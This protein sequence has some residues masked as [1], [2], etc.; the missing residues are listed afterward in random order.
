M[1]RRLARCLGAI[2]LLCP[3]IG[4][5]AFFFRAAATFPSLVD[6][7]SYRPDS[8]EGSSFEK[9]FADSQGWVSQRDKPFRGTGEPVRIWAKFDVP[10]ASEA[11]RVFLVTSAWERVEYFVV[12]DG[13]LVDRQLVGALVPWDKRTTRVTMTPAAF[14]AGLAGVDL[15]AQSKV[16]I[17]A[18][19]ATESRFVPIRNLRISL[20]DANVVREGEQRDRYFQGAFLGVMVLL[21][22]YSLAQ[23]ALSDREVSYLYWA[24][25][26]AFGMLSWG[27]MYGSTLEFLWPNHPAWDY[28]ALWIGLPIGIW[29]FIELWRH[30]LD[31]GKY[32]PKSDALL[33]WTGYA[34][35]MLLPAFLLPFAF[36]HPPSVYATVITVALFTALATPLFFGVAILAVMKR[37]PLARLALAALLCS[38]IGSL[39]TLGAWLEWL[40]ETEWLLN[41]SQVGSVV[42]GVLLSVSLGLRMRDLRAE[43]ARRQIEEARIE[44]ERR[45]LEIAG[46]HKSEF[47]ANMSHELRTPLNAIIGFS[48]VMISGM[49]GPL[50]DKQKEFSGDIR[51]SGRHLLSLINDILDLSKIE[52]GRMELEITRFDVREAMD[53]AL[54]LVR[55]RAELHGINLETHIAENVGHY[56]GD[57]RKF[58]QIVLNLLT[59]AVKFTPDGG[60]VTL[61]AER[62][63]EACVFSV[64]DTGIGIAPEDQQKIFEEFRQVG[65]DSARK[66]EGTGLG[67]ALTK[68]LVELHGGRL[69]VES[70]Q[71]VGSTF[72]F[73][74]PIRSPQD[75]GDLHQAELAKQA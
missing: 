46:K 15:P 14:Q 34:G 53:N 13:R 48:E 26:L 1:L 64:K 5:A 43:M 30:Y 4:D 39:I 25:A 47:L 27:V 65:T 31:T 17:F 23:Y 16:T 19:L 52:A 63:A 68:R 66:A 40:P 42:T 57:Q 74:L 72:A 71:G 33:K 29:S 50:S 41:A 61:A 28:Y 8:P 35:L 73:E 11:R 75:V 56:D 22:L 9:V 45:Q 49:A 62:T 7:I 67:L 32:F 55:G 18:R 10:P 70:T 51:D 58:K 6:E 38:G 37:H 44:G 59:N 60:T 54:T 36:D 24:I 69:Y 12:S 20:W 21:V 2:L 3:L